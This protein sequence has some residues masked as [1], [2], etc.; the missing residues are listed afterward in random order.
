[1]AAVKPAAACP[2]F[3][4]YP[5]WNCPKQ[6]WKGGG[7]FGSL[8]NICVA[9]ENAK[10]EWSSSTKELQ[11][12][13]IKWVFTLRLKPCSR[14]VTVKYPACSVYQSR[15][16]DAQQGRM[17][18]HWGDQKCRLWYQLPARSDRGVNVK[19]SFALLTCWR[20]TF[21]AISNNC[22]SEL[23]CRVMGSSC[24]CLRCCSSL[25]LNTHPSC[26]RGS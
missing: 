15:L 21:K 5:Q 19:A 13:N 2:N 10:L 7:G 3:S 16:I 23:L 1:M 12:S 11:G 6:G 24:P 20:L 22:R 9:C 18:W 4:L 26:Y 8:V 14:A 17:V 25:C